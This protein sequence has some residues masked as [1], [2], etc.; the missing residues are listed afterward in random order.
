[1]DKVQETPTR[2]SK[3]NRMSMRVG[4]MQTTQEGHVKVEN[5]A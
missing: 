1:M 2:S 5:R 4:G 3:N